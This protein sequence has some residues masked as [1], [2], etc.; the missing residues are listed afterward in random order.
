MRAGYGRELEQRLGKSSNVIG[1][2][3]EEQADYLKDR[4]EDIIQSQG[5]LLQETIHNNNKHRMQISPGQDIMSFQHQ[6]MQPPQVPQSEPLFL[7]NSSSYPDPQQLQQ[8]E[9]TGYNSPRKASIPKMQ[10]SHCTEQNLTE[11]REHDMHSGLQNHS[12]HEPHLYTDRPLESPTLNIHTDSQSNPSSQDHD[13]PPYDLLYALTDLYFRH[14][15]TWC[16]I[17][18]RR[19]TLDTLFGRPSSLDEADRILLHSIVATTLRFSI[20]ERLNGENRQRYHDASKR[21]VLLYGLENSSVKALQALVILA[22]DLVGASNGPPGWNLLALITRSV[23]QL[24][25]AVETSTSAVFSHYP[26]I[27]TLRAIILPEPQSWIEDESRRRLFW[28]VYLLDRYATIATAFEFALNDTEIDRKL[29]CRDDLFSRNQPVETRW[30]RSSERVGNS[31]D[32]PEN[33]GSFS[34]YIEVLGILSRVHQF[35][36]QAVDISAASDV[37]RW[38]YTYRELDNNLATWSASL[39]PE[40]GSM[41]RIFNTGGGNKIVNP[42]WVMLHACFHT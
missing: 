22:L 29:P 21:K 25:L 28:M 42:L 36:K 8:P 34:Y 30:F 3:P 20:D 5:R 14:I 17:L 12:P 32:K 24:G 26:S 1:I 15:N 41:A 13:F 37:E 9:L 27:Y 33:L 19:T 2:K 11:S 38:Q 18:H 7:S 10:Q 40:Y 39:P 23:V 31:L 4:L 6:S 35:L 16:P